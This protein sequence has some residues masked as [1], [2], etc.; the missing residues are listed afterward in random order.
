MQLAATP[1]PMVRD[2][3]EPKVRDHITADATET[4]TA[5]P[6]AQDSE[7]APFQSL[8]QLTNK[9]GHSK[10]TQGLKNPPQSES[11]SDNDDAE[12]RADI[13]IGEITQSKTIKTTPHR[14]SE[15]ASGATL[16]PH[17]DSATASLDKIAGKLPS[18]AGSTGAED[19]TALTT[20]RNV[21][22]STVTVQQNEQPSAAATA[23]RLTDAKQSLSTRPAAHAQ[24]ANEIIPEVT[25]RSDRRNST[26]LQSV[27]LVTEAGTSK[28]MAAATP[29]LE[30][31]PIGQQTPLFAEGALTAFNGQA[32]PLIAASIDEAI[33][34]SEQNKSIATDI[35][36]GDIDTSIRSVSQGT[37]TTTATAELPRSFE[38]RVPISQQVVSIV[39]E[40]LV[41]ITR[42]GDS[43][44]AFR[45]DPPELGELLVRVSRSDEGLA[46][47]VTVREPVTLEMLLSRGHQIESGLRGESVDLSE[48][49]F[50]LADHQSSSS[51]QQPR[52]QLDLFSI[53][54]QASHQTR[55]V[56]QP[57]GEDNQITRQ[58]ERNLIFRA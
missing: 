41:E 24:V 7:R 40:H 39:R 35:S 56:S 54:E 23:A 46:L 32:V 9:A 25:A 51:E 29:Q 30:L 16:S 2:Q 49:S 6:S 11:N 33:P 18:N 3:P 53:E 21:S 48:L 8:I 58:V 34:Q 13:A 47:K 27:E 37:S 22:A 12:S 52:E 36:D 42:H 26:S 10:Q 5:K 55:N 44:L 45:L 15:M 31:R 14:S 17:I 20:A 1:Q 38:S 43:S 19:S 4:R 28:P 50:Q 57:S